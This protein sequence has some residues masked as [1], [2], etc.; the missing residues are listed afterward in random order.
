[1]RK[2]EKGVITLEACIV[3]PFFIFL[4]L[5][6]YGFIVMFMG[7]QAMSHALLQSAKSLSLEAYAID[8]LDGGGGKNIKQVFTELSITDDEHF[9]STAK[10]FSD[11]KAQLQSIV[12]DRFIGYLGGTQSQAEAQLELFGVKDGW[13]G[14]DFSATTVENGVLTIHVKYQQEFIYDFNGLLAFDRELS[15]KMKLWGC[16]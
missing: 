16:N 9:A 3:V 15:V 2:N 7:R 10:W 14:M 13:N 12:E 8:N 4:M 1:M 11:D 5:F 6:V